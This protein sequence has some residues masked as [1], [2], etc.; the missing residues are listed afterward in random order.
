MNPIMNQFELSGRARVRAMFA[1]RLK[2]S[3]VEAGKVLGISYTR[4][5]RREKQGK[6]DLRIRH[7]EYGK[8]FILV[9]DLAGY[10]FPEEQVSLPS[11]PPP[12]K[13]RAP[14]RPRKGTE[15]GGR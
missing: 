4:I 9:D 12:D 14:G 13:K 7:D 6:L 3:L 2:I 15:G 10:L 11:P 8:K 5:Y 1:P